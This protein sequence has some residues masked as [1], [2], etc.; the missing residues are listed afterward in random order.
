ME[1]ARSVI[2][3]GRQQNG[4]IGAVQALFNGGLARGI[5]VGVLFGAAQVFPL[6][7]RKLKIVFQVMYELQATEKILGYV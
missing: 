6:F 3:E 4:S 2:Q 7:F 1:A 5:V